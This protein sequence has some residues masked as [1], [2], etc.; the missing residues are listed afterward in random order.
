MSPATSSARLPTPI[1]RPHLHKP[2]VSYRLFLFQTFDYLARLLSLPQTFDSL[3]SGRQWRH[4][5][6]E[7]DGYQ[8]AR[9]S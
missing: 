4:I 6:W 7:Y 8:R 3:Y 1:V 5:F 2:V 9:D